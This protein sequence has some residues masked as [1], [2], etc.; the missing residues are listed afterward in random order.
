MKMKSSARARDNEEEQ[1]ERPAV[2]VET[3]DRRVISAAA[4]RYAATLAAEDR[5]FDA[6]SA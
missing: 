1:D 3:Q 4:R 5:G 2:E 6:P